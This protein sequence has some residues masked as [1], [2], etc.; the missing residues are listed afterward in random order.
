MDPANVQTGDLFLAKFKGYPLWPVRILEVIKTNS[1]DNKFTIFWYDKKHDRQVLSVVILLSF[2][3]NERET[4]T[5][6]TKGANY[7][8]A[9]LKNHP[10]V[11]RQFLKKESNSVIDSLLSDPTANL[12]RLVV[13]T[14]NE[15]AATKKNIAKEIEVKID[16]KLKKSSLQTAANFHA[17]FPVETLVSEINDTVH[18]ETYP[19]F[20]LIEKHLETCIRMITVWLTVC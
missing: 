11:Y 2:D 16:E 13:A 14:Q 1:G 7:V 18:V 20:E 10:G 6:K 5:K 3:G 4:S 12:R 15:L 9:V 17:K 19:K 8:F